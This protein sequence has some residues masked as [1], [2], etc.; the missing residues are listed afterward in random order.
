MFSIGDKI[1]CILS[2]NTEYTIDS[3]IG[4]DAI[5]IIIS[6]QQRRDHLYLRKR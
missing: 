2:I 4:N 3:Y 6:S 5:Q 1:H